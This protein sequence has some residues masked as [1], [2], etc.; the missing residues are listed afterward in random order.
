MHKSKAALFLMELLL[1]LLFFSIAGA[2]CLQLFSRAHIMNREN[3]HNSNANILFTNEAE[4]FYSS[5]DIVEPY[6]V[7][8]NSHLNSMPAYGGEY[9]VSVSQLYDGKYR[10]CHIIVSDIDSENIYID[11]TISEYER[12]VLGDE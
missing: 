3:N 4:A 6:T 7:Y 8:Y 10:I 2:V 9:K 12:S 11:E 5:E 1:A